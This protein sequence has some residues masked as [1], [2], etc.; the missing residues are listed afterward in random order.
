MT[1]GRVNDLR[2]AQTCNSYTV[3]GACKQPEKDS[4]CNSDIIMGHVNDLRDVQ[5]VQQ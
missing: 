4:I 3:I 1:M 5:N 2:D